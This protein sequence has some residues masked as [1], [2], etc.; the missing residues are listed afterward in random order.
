M[1]CFQNEKATVSR[2]VAQNKELKERL[3]ETEDRFV[4]LTEEKATVELAKQSAEHQV[5]ELTKQLNL[6]AAGLVGNLSDVIA[7]QSHLEATSVST[8]NVETLHYQQR[9]NQ[10]LENINTEL[11]T[12]LEAL[13]QEN[14]DIRSDL[15]QKTQE[16]QQVRADLRRSTTHNE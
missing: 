5:R 14:F 6:E 13:K 9:D 8:E 2:A 11:K 10:D 3:L 15:D 1:Y 7:S 4:V 16:L 12:T